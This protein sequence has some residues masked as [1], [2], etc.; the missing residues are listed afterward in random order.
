[1]G[2]Y[3]LIETVV[4]TCN[5]EK[6]IIV[7]AGKEGTGKS[8]LALDI[9]K[10]LVQDTEDVRDLMFADE[11]YTDK[12]IK[13]AFELVKSTFNGVCVMTHYAENK[14]SLKVDLVN[15]LVAS[16][17]TKEEA[18][19]DVFKLVDVCIFLSRQ[20]DKFLIDDVVVMS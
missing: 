2:R 17:W 8:T 18:E 13:N 16:G 4:K 1:M 6:T 14:E 3:N 5:K 12:R 10:A 7:I 15:S 20:G 9:F 11:V 19:R